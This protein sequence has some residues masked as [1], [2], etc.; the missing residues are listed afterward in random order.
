MLCTKAVNDHVA[1]VE[2]NLVV[3]DSKRAIW[4]KSINNLA[5]VT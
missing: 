5:G 4:L 1:G 2:N 3:V